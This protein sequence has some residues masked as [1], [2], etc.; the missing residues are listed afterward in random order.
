MDLSN[1]DFN[2]KTPVMASMEASNDVSM[3]TPMMGLDPSNYVSLQTPKPMLMEPPEDVTL[4]TPKPTLIELNSKKRNRPE[5]KP[6]PPPEDTGPKVTLK[7]HIELPYLQP[8]VIED[9]AN[10]II[11]SQDG[12]VIE[13]NPWLLVS[14]SD[15]MKVVLHDCLV[16]QDQEAV[17][18]TNLSYTD[19]KNFQEF[20]MKGVLP[21][22]KEDICNDRMD[23]HMDAVFAS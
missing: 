10:L 7:S 23:P 22:P 6:E 17:I 9:F 8:E 14:C 16:G 15:L 19:L 11:K 5:K 13:V 18:S 2:L 1:N 3:K 4:Q 20:I 12:L 21:C